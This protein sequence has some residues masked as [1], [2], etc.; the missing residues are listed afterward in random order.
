[1]REEEA[2][3][4]APFWASLSSR[5]GRADNQ[6]RCGEGPLPGGRVF[7]VADGLGGHAGGA[8]AAEAC[9]GAV[10]AAS[11][12]AAFTPD[13]LRTLFEAAHRAVQD[14]QRRDPAASGCRTTAVVLMLSEGRALWG[15]VGD[16]RL[17]HLRGGRVVFQTLD[18]SVPQALVQTGA[19]EPS[20][21][22]RHP[23]RN[24]LL[25][26]LGGEEDAAPA[27]LEAPRA[28]EA[29]DRFLLCSD[30]LWEHV[31]EAEMEALGAGA[32]DPDTWLR[33]LEARLLETASGAFDNYSAT[34]VFLA[35]PGAPA[36]RA[37]RSR[38]ALALVLAAA[39]LLALGFQRCLRGPAAGPGHVF[40]AQP[41][42]ELPVDEEGPGSARR[43]R[44]Q[45]SAAGPRCLAGRA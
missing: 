31:T 10:L 12:T 21:I 7:V 2:A 19:I 37:G 45:S 24:R 22:R 11:R 3:V 26:S 38:L 23:D 8:V 35:P 16:T 14:A 33:R 42:C 4:G 28:L 25:R 9:V 39:F 13:A 43:P 30:G 5:G 32:A 44:L 6:D 15:H 27:L 36:P 20:E 41:A 40:G 17:Y 1:M 34:A 18:H 29:G